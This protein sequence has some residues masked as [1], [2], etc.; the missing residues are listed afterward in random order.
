MKTF[1]FRILFLS[2]NFLIEAQRLTHWDGGT[3]EG[4]ASYL[5]EN[6]LY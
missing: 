2:C 6:K 4:I 1:F 3:G 5:V